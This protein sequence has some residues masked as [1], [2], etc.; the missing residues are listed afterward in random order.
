MHTPAAVHHDSSFFTPEK[1]NLTPGG[2]PFSGFSPGSPE[3]E[4]IFSPIA[5]KNAP[6]ATD[7]LNAGETAAIVSS[8]VGQEF[9]R[10]KNRRPTPKWRLERSEGEPLSKKRKLAIEESAKILPEFPKNV[11]KR[12]ETLFSPQKRA[13]PCLN[14]FGATTR[15]PNRQILTEIP[16]N[17]VFSPSEQFRL[18]PLPIDDFLKLL[19]GDFSNQPFKKMLIF[20]CR[21][22]YEFDAARFTNAIN[23][24]Y[25]DGKWKDILK[26]YT[27]ENELVAQEGKDT[28]I[29]FHCEFSKKRGKLE[30]QWFRRHDR[31]VNRY[32]KLTFPHVRLLEGGFRSFWKKYD[33]ENAP[34]GTY[35]T[36]LAS[37]IPNYVSE[38]SKNH[39]TNQ[40][41]SRRAEKK[42]KRENKMRNQLFFQD[43]PSSPQPI[44]IRGLTTPDSC[45]RSKDRHLRSSV[46]QLAA[47][48]ESSNSRNLHAKKNRKSSCKKLF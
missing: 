36:S 7:T 29:V 30:H 9:Q 46:T 5:Q 1:K 37:G 43:G 8:V 20:D 44:R 28:V 39:V 32:P 35:A 16:T 33:F 18:Q 6:E 14:I 34:A 24:D 41:S 13:A 45:T 2:I 4:I 27:F 22:Q 11:R 40:K 10:S 17:S 21:Y 38:F 47:T 31:E 25:S 23:A 42:Q 3:P 19:E 26:K 48:P 12:A 15:T